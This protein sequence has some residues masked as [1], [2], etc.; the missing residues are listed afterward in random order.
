LLLDELNQ[1]LS[2]MKTTVLS[3]LA[4]TLA[5]G[6]VACSGNGDNTDGGDS[7]VTA[8]TTTETDQT[9]T[10]TATSTV[11][12]AAMADSFSVGN[13]EGRYLDPKT[14]KSIKIKVDPQTGQRV[15][16]ETGE[17]VWRYVDRRTWWVYSGDDWEP[18]GEAR[19]E[20][21]NLQYKG[22]NATWMTY[23]ERW[24]DDESQ[25]NDW[26]KKYADGSKVE[27]QDNGN[28]KYKNENIKVKTEKDG[29]IKIKT[30]DGKKI[31]KDEDGVR[32]KDDNK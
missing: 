21:S 28:T 9:S 3:L 13:N 10:T 12:Y 15:N 26:K 19:M 14:G 22:D 18:Q 31:K 7:T 1:K 27:V 5:V 23:D 4:T 8:S 29:D 25:M 2:N 17:P 32:V 11:D 24:P 6:F 16:T 20:G 30:E